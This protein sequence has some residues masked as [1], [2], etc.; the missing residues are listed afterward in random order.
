MAILAADL[1]FGFATEG[2]LQQ[3]LCVEGVD[4]DVLLM[5]RLA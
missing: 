2:R 4:H 1:A 5:A 3:C